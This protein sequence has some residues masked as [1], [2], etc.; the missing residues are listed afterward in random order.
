MKWIL[1]GLVVLAT[2]WILVSRSEP[3]ASTSP[4]ER[5]EIIDDLPEPKEDLSGEFFQGYGESAEKDLDLVRDAIEV[6][7]YSVKIPGALPTAGN[8]EIVR[9]LCGENAY[10]IR[11]LDPSSKFFNGDGE[12]VDRWGTPL[13]FHFQSAE[14][15]G[16]RSAGPD[17]KMWTD[18]DL[19]SIR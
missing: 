5:L 1:I 2:G 17:R 6:F 19:S 15:P 14:E 4:H 12:L 10:G 9:A 11:F 7:N 13:Y 16:I 3:A 8:R 18:D